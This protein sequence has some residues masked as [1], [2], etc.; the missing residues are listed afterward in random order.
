MK[1]LLAAVILIGF[2]IA[3]VITGGRSAPSVSAQQADYVHDF[4]APDSMDDFDFFVTNGRNFSERPTSWNGDHARGGTC[5]APSTTRTIRWPDDGGDETPTRTT[6]PGD[7]VYWCAP[8]GPGSGH[9]MTTFHTVGYAH[10]DFSPKRTFDYVARV[11]WDQNVTN[12]GNRKWTQVAIAPVSVARDVAPRLDWTHPGF[13][14]NFGPAS[15][16][17]GL[18]GGVFLFS[19]TQGNAETYTGGGPSAQDFSNDP[20]VTDKIKRVTTCLTD[21]ENG[22]IK[23]EQERYSGRVETSVMPGAFPNG[24]VRVVFQDVSYDPQKAFEESAPR[25]TDP[26]TWH[27][28]NLLISAKG[29]G[30]LPPSPTPTPTPD[31][32]PAPTPVPP[33]VSGEFDSM[34]PTRLVDTRPGERTVDSR[35]AGIG[36]LDAGSVTRVK[37]AGRGGVADDA[38]GASLSITSV[39]PIG[40]G[41]T[42]V[43][44]CGAKPGTSTINLVHGT[45]I[46]N[47]VHSALSPNGEICIYT[48]APVHLL[49]DVNGVY[50]KTSSFRPREPRRYLET[51][52]GELTFDGKSAGA[53]KTRAGT[54]IEIPI[55][56]RGEVPETATAVSLNLTAVNARAAGYASVVEC[57][58]DDKPTTSNLN[59]ERSV[60]RANA[61]LVPLSS[62]GTLCIYTSATTDLIV[63]VNGWFVS[64]SGYR[65]LT[66]KRYADT[67]NGEAAFDGASHR[68]NQLTGVTEV[69]VESRGDIPKQAGAVAVQLTVTGGQSDGFATIFPCDADRPLASNVNYRRNETSS[70]SAVSRISVDGTVCVFT[71]SRADVI[72]DVVGWFPE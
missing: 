64:K 3:P 47:A 62:D 4:E 30:P 22:D 44:P 25:V 60:P 61:A 28:D 43:Y 21:L 69:A 63:D 18:D 5:G 12:L 11:C 23:V 39:D 10:V 71:R 68:P 70:V 65:A 54:R 50:P 16:G 33:S 17:L 67:R 34:V 55:A 26:Y 13:R 36:R 41:F 31:P 56:G 35:Y 53:G 2:G 59:Y 29:G 19:S 1:K 49:V 15:W 6:D 20:D 57:D 52:P 7:T 51:R 27:W 37:V 72:V 48:T 46:A 58:I 32:D 14:D 8:G 66:A 9:L 24:Q 42:A 45:I 40:A 38:S